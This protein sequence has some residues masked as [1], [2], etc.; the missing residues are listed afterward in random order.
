MVARIEAKKKVTLCRPQID[1]VVGLVLRLVDFLTLPAVA[2]GTPRV[3]AAPGQLEREVR[4]AHVFE[5]PNITVSLEGAEIL[6]TTGIATA[7]MDEAAIGRLVD[8][9]STAGVAGLALELGTV[10]ADAPDALVAACG[11]AELPLI[12][13]ARRVKFVEI[14]H[15]VAELQIAAELQRLRRAVGV[16]A[17]L[18]EAARDGHGAAAILTAL[19]AA[20]EAELLV[21][22]AD[23][24]PILT[25]PREDG[26][27]TAFL[28]ALADRRRGEQTALVTHTVVIP[29][30]RMARLH[31]LIP[32]AGEL[33]ELTVS[34]TA[35]LL[36]AA[37]A[38]EPRIDELLS[39]DRAR[40]VRLLADGR[41]ASQTDVRRRI[42]SVGH[43]VP[44]E[45]VGV[46]VARGVAG[47]DLRR[48][49]GVPVIT[50][51]A[52]AGRVRAVLLAD[53]ATAR[54]A[55][56]RVVA[57]ALGLAHAAAEPMAIR[58]AFE[59]AGRAS[60]VAHALG[61]PLVVAAE[62]GP[63]DPVAAA[64]LQGRRLTP[65][66]TERDER[67]LGALVAS[68]FSVAPAARRLGVSRQSVYKELRRAEA[69]LGVRP[70]D[71]GAHAEISLRL[72]T[73][74]MQRAI[75]L[76]G[77]AW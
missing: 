31:A 5:N 66:L 71:P 45:G 61:R 6:L 30:Q 15:A 43:D 50:E 56:G 1:T 70:L 54:L 52:P 59:L 65:S 4:W 58:D 77:L 44:A 17:R 14:T 21:E 67:L 19:A 49:L 35:F 22:A 20:L 18:R 42:R 38:A 2:V 13:F 11:R 29:G 24:T 74:R 60:L 3:L 9:L 48:A 26:L 16:Q 68:G 73:F 46:L 41:L 33:D 23:G 36:G 72:V 8:D 47:A 40:L 28:E 7:G 75:E 12:A 32:E 27:S 34:E 63:L 37:L 10:Y 55:A 39:D 57:G 76:E 62:M 25:A 64:V 69:R 53:P 51:S